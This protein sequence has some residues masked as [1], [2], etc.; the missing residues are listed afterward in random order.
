MPSPEAAETGGTLPT[1]TLPDA[2]GL[3]LDRV[4]REARGKCFESAGSSESTEGS[5]TGRAAAGR[6]RAAAR[7]GY[8]RGNAT[9]AQFNGGATE[10]GA[11][12]NNGEAEEEEEEEE[13]ADDAEQEEFEAVGER[14][15][16]L[17]TVGRGVCC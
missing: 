4:E 5:R 12:G 17:D 16:R 8:K 2:P 1:S 9:A 7:C 13:T 11:G 3:F 10:G 14:G 15:G 6:R